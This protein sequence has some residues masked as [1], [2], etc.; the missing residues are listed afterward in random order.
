MEY[1]LDVFGGNSGSA[2]YSIEQQ[3]VIGIHTF[4]SAWSLIE[5]T[6]K[7]CMRHNSCEQSPQDPSCTGTGGLA[8]G[9]PIRE[10]PSY[11]LND[12]N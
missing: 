10:I 3:A 8:G 2:I 5:D 7:G 9:M 6:H 4:G 12:L 1:N 11:F